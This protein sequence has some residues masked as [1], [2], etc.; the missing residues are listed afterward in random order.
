MNELQLPLAPPLPAEVRERALAK[1]LAEAEPTRRRRG[2]FLAVAAAVVTTLA[3]TTSVALLG[4]GQTDLHPM[5]PPTP[6]ESWPISDGSDA[7]F[8]ARCANAVQQ[9]GHAG[10]YPPVSE[11]RTQAMGTG[12]LETDIVINDSFACQLRP[13]TVTVSPPLTAT[14]AD[15]TLVRMASDRL[16]LLNPKNL[17]VTIGA[18]PEFSII[19]GGPAFPPHREGRSVDLVAFVVAHLG[20]IPEDVRIKVQDGPVDAISY[21]GPVV[22]G[23]VDMLPPLVTYKDRPIP[24]TPDSPDVAALRDC[25]NLPQSADVEPELWR[26]LGRHEV[27]GNPKALVAKIGEVGV[28]FCLLEPPPGHIPDLYRKF[29]GFPLLPLERPGA[30]QF[31]YGGAP[32]GELR[33]AM[34]RVPP[35]V[36]RVQMTMRPP[37]APVQNADCS[38]LSDI[39]MCTLPTPAD[40]ATT[41]FTTFTSHDPAAPGT[42]VT[43]DGPR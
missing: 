13:A 4:V 33:E 1:V 17:M 7:S 39:A 18:K 38:V 6:A 5:L 2:P 15:L 31:L 28:G 20:K 37:G 21:D 25:M 11:W 32:V 36:V 43:F 24:E 40:L 3:V 16:V 26:P 12:A 10:D 23:P 19:L 9:S 27:A 8:I 41:T 29:Q 34:L 14:S 30:A 22:G 35:G 42:T